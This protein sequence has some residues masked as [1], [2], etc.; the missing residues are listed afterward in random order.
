MDPRQERREL[1]QQ[2]F[3]I[4]RYVE[5]ENVKLDQKLKDLKKKYEELEGFT[6]WSEFP[7]RWDIGDP[8][9]V[10]MGV[11]GNEVDKINFE[12]AF[13]KPYETIIHKTIQLTKNDIDGRK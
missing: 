3:F 13:G 8:N 1:K 9:K 6:S 2:L 11:W 10:K 5:G 4:R 7:D 12:K